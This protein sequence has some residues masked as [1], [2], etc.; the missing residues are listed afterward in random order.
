MQ[1]ELSLRVLNCLPIYAI[2][3][4]LLRI[5]VTRYFQWPSLVAQLV[6]NLPAMQQNQ[7][8]SLDQEDPLEK[9]KATPSSIL[10]CRI[11]WTVQYMGSQELDTTEQLSL[12]FIIISASHVMR[13]FTITRKN[14][15]I[16]FSFAKIP[17]KLGFLLLSLNLSMKIES[18]LKIPL[19]SRG[20]SKN[21]CILS[22]ISQRVQ[23]RCSIMSH[24][25]QP[26][27]L[28]HAWPPCC[29]C[30]KVT[31]VGSDSV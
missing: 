21:G 7:V 30:C 28:Q 12:S 23:F 27:G 1:E 10:A 26:H 25:L 22:S 9:R 16:N 3:Q 13:W 2:T 5:T 8:R 17:Q 15:F 11:P 4:S 14:V 29:Y 20:P 31:S 19:H 18:N 24:S 6:K